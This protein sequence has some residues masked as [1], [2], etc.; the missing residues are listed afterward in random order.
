VRVS[1]EYLGSLSDEDVGRELAT[2]QRFSDTHEEGYL[3]VVA[4][5]GRREETGGGTAVERGYVVKEDATERQAAHSAR[6]AENARTRRARQAEEYAD[7]VYRSWLAAESQTRG[8]LL[9][10]AGKRADIEPRTLFTGPESRVRKYASPELVEFFESH[11]RPTRETFLGS[12]RQ[13]REA[14]SRRR[15]G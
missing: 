8:N 4:E 2:Y 10:A 9:N 3:Q 1:R 13:R 15:I 6:V 11:P 5:A 12:Q 14:L 7:E